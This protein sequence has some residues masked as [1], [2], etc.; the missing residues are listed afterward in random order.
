MLADSARLE[1][2]FDNLFSNALKVLPTGGALCVVARI[3]GERAEILVRDT[4]PGICEA[5]R[6][7]LF[8]QQPPN[9][10]DPTSTGVGL[11]ICREYM[12]A[13][14]GAIALDATGPEGTTFRLTL[15]LAPKSAAPDEGTA[16]EGREG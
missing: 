7:A 10:A 15:R 13:M 14:Q 12:E 8:E 5:R 6:G 9:P 1:I 3:E 2:V 16:P 11:S 4:G